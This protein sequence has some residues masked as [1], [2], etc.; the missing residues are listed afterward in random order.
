MIM[1][2]DM[3]QNVCHAARIALRDS[4]RISEVENSLESLQ[5]RIEYL[6]ERKFIRLTAGAC[7]KLEVTCF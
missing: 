5:L 3:A 2:A 7:F 6:Q 1:S 4:K